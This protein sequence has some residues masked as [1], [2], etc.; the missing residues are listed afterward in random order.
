MK[1]FV[2]AGLVYAFC[3][4]LDAC[5]IGRNHTSDASLER[6]FNEHREEFD[7]LLTEMQGDPQLT[8]FSERVITYADRRL[9]V[10]EGDYIEAE[11]IGLPK[12]HWEQYRK[13]CQDLG[14]AQI[15]RG[16]NGSVEL[17]VDPGTL[18]NG[19]TYKGFWYQPAPPAN[20]LSGLD[21]YRLTSQSPRVRGGWLVYKHLAGNWYLYLFVRG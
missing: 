18:F 11:R 3:L 21:D 16:E 8:S 14:L 20:L 17:R 19:D 5:A 9:E 7:Q 15:G 13:G 10:K 4:L 6:I 2:K 1:I 12:A